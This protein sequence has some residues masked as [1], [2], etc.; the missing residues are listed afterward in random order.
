MSPSTFQGSGAG[1][2]MRLPECPS[3]DPGYPALLTERV[4]QTSQMISQ[5]ISGYR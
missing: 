3:L 1:A 2:W 4:I 5:I